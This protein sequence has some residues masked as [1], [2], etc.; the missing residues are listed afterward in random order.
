MRILEAEFVQESDTGVILH[1]RTICFNRKQPLKLNIK[2]PRIIVFS[3][4][5]F[6]VTLKH[7][8][9]IGFH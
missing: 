6:S 3:Q 5:R 1:F 2:A 7:T 4:V 8:E 9:T